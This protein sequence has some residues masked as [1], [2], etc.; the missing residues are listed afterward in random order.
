MRKIGEDLVT[1]PDEQSSP[2][3]T[4]LGW[5]ERDGHQT[6]RRST[7]AG[8]DGRILS[9]ATLAELRTHLATIHARFQELYGHKN[10]DRFAMEIEF[11]ITREGNLVIKQARPWVY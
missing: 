2:E 6:V 10:E 3:E 5:W 8:E 9:D 11:K 1:N 7:Q 4:L